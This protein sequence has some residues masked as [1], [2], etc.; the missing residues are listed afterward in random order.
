V[1][2]RSRYAVSVVILAIALVVLPHSTWL[3]VAG[4]VGEY[5]VDYSGDPGVV[6]YLRSYGC[7]VVRD[8]PLFGV[9]LV[10]CPEAIAR[11]YRLI[12]NFEVSVALGELRVLG[13]LRS[14]AQP[15]YSYTTAWSWAVSRVGADLVWGYLNRS[16]EGVVVAVLDTGVDPTHPLL[17]GKL[18]TVDP[19][20]PR[21]PGGWIEF[22]RRGRPVCTTPRDTHGH[23]T[24]VSSILVGGDTSNYVFGVAPQARLMVAAVLQGGYGTAA[25]VLA[26]LEWV[27]APYDCL[28]RYLNI[29]RPAVV[30]MSLGA[31][32]N[33]SNVFLPA[34]RRL[35]E[36]GVVPV[37]AIGN[38]GP[39]VTAN[40]GNIWG[41]IGVGATDVN[42][43]VARFSSFEEVEWPAPPDSWP[44]KGTYPRR[45]PKPDVVAPGVEVAGA[46]P[47]NLLAIGSGTSAAT[48]LVAGIAALVSAELS[49]RGLRGP[50]LVEAVYD[51]VTSTARRL[52]DAGSGYGR[53]VAYGAVAKAVDLDVKVL[54]VSISPSTAKPGDSVR[55][56][57]GVYPGQLVEVL[58]SGVR[59]FSGEYPAGGV[60]VRVPDTHMDG[61]TVV[62]LADGG[63]A[64]GEALLYVRPVLRVDRNTTSGTLLTL[65]VSGLGFVDTLAV[66]LADTLL[67]LDNT[68]LRGS[69]T[70]RLVVPYVARQT[71]LE[72]RVEDLSVPGLTL[73]AGI[74]VAPPPTAPVTVEVV[75]QL[76]VAVERYYVVGRVGT[77]GVYMPEEGLSV[78][79][80][81]LHPGDPVVSLVKIERTG[82]L[83]ML[84]VNVTAYPPGGYAY[85]EVS[86]CSETYCVSSVAP[87][88]VVLEDPAERV[89]GEVSKLERALRGVEE[90]L[91]EALTRLA[92]LN[93]S[94]AEASG[95][96]G[97]ALTQVSE[98][99]RRVEN[100]ES[101]LGSVRLELVV[102]VARVNATVGA[103]LRELRSRVSSLEGSVAGLR[104]FEARLESYVDR[105]QLLALLAL[106]ISATVLAIAVAVL[107]VSR[108]GRPGP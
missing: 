106:A 12:P 31:L 3:V 86:A 19:K 96:A 57:A 10:E 61:N 7:T 15:G 76:G 42:D 2:P 65:Q 105:A 55:V 56:V 73:T 25:Q 72:L 29:P 98:L 80:R 67:L 37:A 32:G 30:S 53:V 9:A 36:L 68:N 84:Y 48:P 60:V 49:R 70:A 69:L 16:G 59:V 50:Q 77:V 26:G 62:V 35:I 39:Y 4:P 64:F 63:R 95:R 104:S 107:T 20:D 82:R 34:I 40:P 21:Y 90:E 71:Y 66:Y 1:H 78:R 97:K 24:W 27:A 51:T 54:P 22:D 102:S 8:F 83:A 18:L 14:L 47:G 103:E 46:Y 101:L 100:L 45:Y 74:T 93:T 58:L 89:L 52:E 108:R 88:Y 17:D 79:V 87:L 11:A 5:L 13:P 28:R 43:R 38:G 81:Q 94:V 33:Y 44:F 75:R 99:L 6:A 23:G 85:L 91:R 92:Y 41:V